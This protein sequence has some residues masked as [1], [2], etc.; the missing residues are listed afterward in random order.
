[1]AAGLTEYEKW[2]FD[3]HGYLILEEI[4]PKDDLDQMVEVGTRWHGLTQEQVPLPLHREGD[5]AWSTPESSPPGP[6]YINNVQYCDEAY[7]RLA[8][9]PEIM[10]VVDALSAAPHPPPLPTA[11]R[12]AGL[13]AGVGRARVQ[14]GREAHADRQR[15]DD[16]VPRRRRQ[17]RRAIPRRDRPAC[18]WR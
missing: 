6:Y 10:R 14:D 3:H 18:P 11:P 15:P 17:K 9:H 16:D 12:L 13:T 1:M 4:V 5:P 2:F 8:L 7:A